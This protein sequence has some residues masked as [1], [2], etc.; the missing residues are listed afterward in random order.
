L[1]LKNE[2]GSLVATGVYVAYLEMREIGSKILKI[3]VVIGK[4]FLNRE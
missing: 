1:D 3:A 4:E 2:S